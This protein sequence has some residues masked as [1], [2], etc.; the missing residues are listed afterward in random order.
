MKF[1]WPLTKRQFDLERAVAADKYAPLVSRITAASELY[2]L[3]DA[4]AEA[5]KELTADYSEATRPPDSGTKIG[6]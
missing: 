5:V 3:W 4:V 6:R 2:G 1:K